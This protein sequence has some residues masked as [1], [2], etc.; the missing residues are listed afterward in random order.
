MN[1]IRPVWGW[2]VVDLCVADEAITRIGKRS[3]NGATVNSSGAATCSV[4]DAAKRWIFIFVNNDEE[5]A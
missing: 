5:F 1:V 3:L 4:R 2:T